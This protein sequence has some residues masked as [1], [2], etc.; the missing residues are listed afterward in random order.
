MSTLRIEVPRALKPLISPVRYKGAYGGRGGAKS[1]FYAEQGIV[2]CILKRT[3]MVCIREVQNSIK[4]SVR[5]L[6]SDKIQKLG[7]GHLFELTEN[8]IRGP[9]DSLIVF[10]GMQSYNAENI[11]SL[12]DY[13]IAWVEEAQTLSQRSLDLLRP[14]IRADNS[15]LW[16]SWNPRFKTDPVDAFFRKSPPPNA[17]SVH[18]G[19]QDNPWFPEVLKQ[20]MAHDFAVDEDKAQ[21]IWNGEYG[22][23]KGA[24]LSKWVS[25]ARREGRINK[26]VSYDPESFPVE[27]STDLGFRDTATFWFWQR[28]LGG[29]VLFDY[30]QDNGLDADD[31]CKR[32]TE[33]LD[34]HGANLHKIYMP[35]DAKTK[36]FASKHS[37]QQRFWKAFGESKIEIVPISSK[38]DRISAAREVIDRCEFH[39]ERCAAGIEGLEA[40]EFEYNDDLGV[41]SREPVHN[42]ASHP[43]DGFSYGCQVMTEDKAPSADKPLVYKG[44]T[45]GT[46]PHV[47]KMTFNDI[48][49][50]RKKNQLETSE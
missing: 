39:V 24:I 44:V 49:D 34:G 8:E 18:V 35:H 42:W 40:W 48:R 26:S 13:D 19:W 6:L 38:A 11:K 33:R 10:K 45:I 41:F 22:S 32:I 1:H 31:W 14:T 46:S 23:L 16:F 27:I 3:R 47:Q 30:D 12:E 4:D 25:K 28:R 15:E 20:E 43:S 21:H 17:V 37:A 29:F 9:N 5:Q 2:K 36:H 50:K 7:I